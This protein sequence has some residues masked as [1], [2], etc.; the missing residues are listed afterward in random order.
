MNHVEEQV[1]DLVARLH[2]GVFAVL[3]DYRDRHRGYLDE[4]LRTFDR[5]VQ[6][7]VANLEYVRR[8]Q[9]AGLPFCYPRVS[10]RSKEVG[11]RDTFDLTLSGKLEDDL[12]R[13]RA[14]L[15][16]ATPRSIVIMNESFTSTTLSDALLISRD[17]LEQIVRLD[18]LC[19]CV[20]FIEELAS[21]GNAAVSMVSTVVPENPAERTYRIVR[22]RADG[23]A[24]AAAIAGKHGLTYER[25]K[26]RLAR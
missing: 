20:T 26:E 23:L 11:A 7:Y 16:Q 19:V 24:Y 6:F 25:L 8:L 1:L 2:P 10:D 14:I 13:I 5:E 18:L 21:L 15:D 17:V 3:D 12:L 9:A 4:T 22:R